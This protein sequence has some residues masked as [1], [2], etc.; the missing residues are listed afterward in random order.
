[1]GASAIRLTCVLCQWSG[2]LSVGLTVLCGL[3]ILSVRYFSFLF[4]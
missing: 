4:T 2:G 3:V 1:M